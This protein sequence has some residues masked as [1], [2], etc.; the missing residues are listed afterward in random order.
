MSLLTLKLAAARYVLGA[1]Q[2]EE[3]PMIADE[4]ITRDVCSP[5]LAE[6]WLTRD[7]TLRDSGPVLEKALREVGIPLPTEA[8][9]A[10]TVA[11]YLITRIVEGSISPRAG[12]RRL[13]EEV[14]GAAWPYVREPPAYW[15]ASASQHFRGLLDCHYDYEYQMEVMDWDQ[16]G[17]DIEVERVPIDQRVMSLAVE[18]HREFC[19]ATVNPDWLSW[20]QG[21]VA[22]VARAIA[23]EHRFEDLPILAD[24]LEEAGCTNAHILDHCREPGEHAQRCWVLELLLNPQ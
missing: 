5:A 6:L 15:A 23:E 21:C 24:A 2:A 16:E 9:A 18:W 19:P 10:N 12:M 1:I 11:K 7:P 22:R 20:N 3:L 4:V 17:T 14:C 8:E 13:V